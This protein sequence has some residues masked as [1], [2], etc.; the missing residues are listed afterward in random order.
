MRSRRRFDV[1]DWVALGYIAVATA[2]LLIPI[3][4]R[5]SLGGQSFSIRLNAWRVEALYVVLFFCIRQLRFPDPWI[6]RTRNAVLVVAVIIAGFAIWESV[7]RAGFN[8]FQIY[9]LGLENY[10]VAVLHVTG[11]NN[12]L[13]TSE[14]LAGTPLVRDGSLFNSAYTLAFFMLIPFGIGLERLAARRLSGL[15][16]AGSAAAAVGILLAVT[17]SAALGATIAAILAVSIGSRQA[18]GRLRLVVVLATAVVVLLPSLSHSTLK[19]RFADAFSA[20]RDSES[21]SHITAIKNG[22]NYLVHDPVGRGLGENTGTGNRFGTGI[23]ATTEDSYLETGLEIGLA[24][25]V[26]QITLLLL[27]LSRL[28]A[29]SRLDGLGAEMAGAMWL[30]G[31][32]I[33]VGAVF[34]QA[35]FDITTALVFWTFAGL[36]LQVKEDAAERSGSRRVALLN[37]VVARA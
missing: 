14:T 11:A 17:R 2:Y 10:S 6:R 1:L 25:M 12:Q 37:G 30:G 9:T 20:K 18:P 28:R 15:V 19:T 23:Q 31:A 7:N 35:W 21:Q 27:L 8:H 33:A 29:R 26:L 13:L 36:A 34:I 16:L 4:A 3:V 5:G 32:A 22:L 24:A